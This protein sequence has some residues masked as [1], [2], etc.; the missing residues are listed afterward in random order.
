MKVLPAT[1]VIGVSAVIFCA[2]IAADFVGGAGGSV[3]SVTSPP[4][5]A[6]SVTGGL[7]GDEQA[8]NATSARVRR[9]MAATLAQS[10]THFS[11][12][13]GFG[14]DA[15]AG[16]GVTDTAGSIVN[17]RSNFAS[18]RHICAVTAFAVRS[19]SQTRWS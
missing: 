7:A 14:V 11:F 4:P 2:G 19:E 12:T 8:A 10:P 1:V 18:P 9:N 13:G 16:A 15:G 6:G 3:G 17:A 5:G